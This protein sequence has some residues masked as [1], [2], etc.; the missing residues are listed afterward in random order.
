MSP[1]NIT[2]WFKEPLMDDE[3]SLLLVSVFDL[4]IVITPVNIE[5]SKDFS[6][7]ELINKV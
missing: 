3:G 4:D 1:K 5:L 2:V 6:S 7:L